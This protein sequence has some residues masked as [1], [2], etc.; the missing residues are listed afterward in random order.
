MSLKNTREKLY[1]D[2][3]ITLF[4]FPKCHFNLI[5]VYCLQFFKSRPLACDISELPVIINKG[6]DERSQNK[7]RKRYAIILFP[8]LYDIP[9]QTIV[10]LLNY[11][12]S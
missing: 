3:I 6:D 4:N 1:F 12:C 7:R 8:A 11:I 2:P 10:N 9:M 5:S